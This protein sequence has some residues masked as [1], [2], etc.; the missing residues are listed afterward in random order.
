MKDQET[1]TVAQ[2]RALLAGRA[3]VAPCPPARTDD[4]A[5]EAVLLAAVRRLAAQYGWL[6]YHTYDS[7]KSALGYPDVTLT[8]G[9]AL[10]IYELKTNT[11][12]LTVA[13]EQWLSRLAQTGTVETGVWRPR[14]MA[15][16]IARLSR[17]A[18]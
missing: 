14:D 10:L 3:V 9:T 13:Q 11:G 12:T 1:M 17:T 16:I 8:D 18:G 2:Y 6:C 5:S 15:A 4:D 7:R